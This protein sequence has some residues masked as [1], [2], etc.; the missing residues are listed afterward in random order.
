LPEKT[1][2][3]IGAGIAGL[4]ASVRL[5]A[6]G[7]RV[8][9]YE[10]NEYPG[11]KLHYFE[12]DGF[13]FDAGPSLFTMPQFVDEL[14]RLA[15]RVPEDHFRY[16]KLDVLCHY[17]YPD[18]TFLRAYADERAFAEECAARTGVDRKALLRHLRKS[19]WIYRAT[20][21]VFIER[22]LHRLSTYLSLQTFVS[23][24]KL[25][26]LNTLRS[27][28]QVNEQVLRNPKMVQLF[29]RYATYNGSDPYQAP[30]ILNLIP[31]LEH[32]L[33]AYLPEGGM[34]SITRSVHRLACDL[35]VR[36]HFGQR[37]ERILV[38]DG[39]ARG[40]VTMGKNHQADLV[41][42]NM[43]VV[44]AYRYLMPEQP[45]PEKILRQE[46]SSSALIYYWGIAKEFP[47]LS[48]HNIFFSADYREEFEHIFRK[49]D[50]SAD[51]TVYIN[52]TS[53]EEPGHA[54][55]GMENW[56]VMV[57]VPANN[58]QD[59]DS[60]IRKTKEHILQK[61]SA[62]LQ[63]DLNALIVTEEIL[64]PRTI[65]ART[66]SYMGALYGTSSNSR[67]A[68]F[69]RHPNFTSRIRDLYFCGGSVHPGGGIPLA[70][71]SARI[72]DQ[73]IRD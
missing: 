32:H 7:Y 27:M 12:K 53:K 25:P 17:F 45:Q 69:F 24:L 16:K 39:R 47:Q 63:T 22:S 15:G 68:A 51:P 38:E 37:V 49:K 60:L 33:G 26:F 2:I 66:G 40:I 19:A 11:G 59:W 64:D 52:I 21:P 29:N 8:D 30:G 41:V 4:A 48:L 1:A 35:G 5:A 73:L 10:V 67:M 58:G 28:N 13:S 36:F 61:L 65:E 42:C 54:P 62:M 71:S 31:H 43:D 14:F 3:I 72:V 23:F 6:R 55:P 57:N 9:V 44:P 34:H 70:L 46:R 18:G 56:F 20:A 50:V